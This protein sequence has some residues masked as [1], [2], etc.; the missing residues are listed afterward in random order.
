LLEHL[1]LDAIPGLVNI[2]PLSIGPN[3]VL[4]WL[5]LFVPD[6]LKK[7]PDVFPIVAALLVEKIEYVLFLN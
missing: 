3:L 5:E 2:V 7:T 4:S 6:V 1:D